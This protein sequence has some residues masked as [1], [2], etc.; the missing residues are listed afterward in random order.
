LSQEERDPEVELVVDGRPLSLAPFVRQ[1]LASTI[2]GMVS[3]LKGAEN[4]QEVSIRVRR[5]S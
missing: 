3:T 4:A 2:L 5:P 1:I